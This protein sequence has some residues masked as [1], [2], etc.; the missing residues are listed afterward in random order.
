MPTLNDLIDGDAQRLD[1]GFIFTEGPLYHPAQ[2]MRSPV[3]VEPSAPEP[4]APPAAWHKRM[5][6]ADLGP[7]FAGGKNPHLE[8]LPLRQTWPGA[9]EFRPVRPGCLSL[10]PPG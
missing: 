1:T 2:L 10:R 9:E 8:T 3:F 5:A 4:D 6:E 7:V